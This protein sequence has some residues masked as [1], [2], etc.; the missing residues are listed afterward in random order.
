MDFKNFVKNTPKQIRVPKI[1]EVS[2]TIDK[3]HFDYK[4]TEVIWDGN[5][6]RLPKEGE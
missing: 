1:K 2:S 6:F 3:L 4:P 5:R